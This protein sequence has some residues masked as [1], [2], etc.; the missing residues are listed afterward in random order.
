MI[1]G[2]IYPIGIQSF[3]ELRKMNCV[4]VD[5]TELIYRL[6]HTSKFV[7]LSRPRRFGK[8]LL[9]ST[10]RCYFE[11][12]KE[13]FTGLAMERL[14]T[15]WTQHPVLHFDLSN[16]RN[17]E[18]EDLERALSLKLDDY[19][20]I[21][22]RNEREVKL[23]ERL[24]GLIKRAYAKSGQKVVVLIDEYD[25]QILDVIHREKDVDAVRHI[26]RDFYSPLK[27]LDEYLRFV[28]FTGISM[29]S[30]LSIF[31]ELNNL[32]IISN[33]REY[34]SICGITEQ[35]LLDNFQEGIEKMAEEYECTKDEMVA[36]LKSSYDGYHFSKYSEGLYN[37]FSL[38]NA[39][40]RKELGSYW[41]A[42]GTP[43]ALIEMLKIYQ[44]QGK[45]TPEMLDSIQPVPVSKFQT[46]L[47]MQT[48]PMSLLYQSGYVT[49]TDYD[50]DDDL[51]YLGIPNSE[52]RVGLM[53]NLLPL[54][55]DVDSSDVEG[56]VAR[57]SA[58]LRKGNVDKAMKLLQS[59]L[60]SIPFMKGDKDILGDAEKT[61]A[62]YHRIF[63]FFFR[64]LH[65]EVTAEVRSAKG[66]TDVVV[67]TPKYIYVIEIKINATPEA[68]LQQIEEKGYATPYLTDGRELVK[69][70]VNF[71]TDTRTIDRWLTT[72]PN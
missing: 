40:S 63:F 65:N 36:K 62:Y 58:A 12:R 60:A 53:Q 32:N 16:P 8:S 13:L 51:Y 25:S 56:T 37:P 47:E 71:S 1:L 3:S 2:P 49:I 55:V 28:F 57:T 5:K 34:A 24:R 43:R 10:L 35:E 70:G 69:L 33:D 4:Y 42:S 30:Q 29:F 9:S 38:L 44:R 39:L 14:E 11:G 50:A 21:Y 41:F 48:G 26:M 52:V 15:D 22:G 31:S 68:A 6:T 17:V 64:M 59:L 54:Y 20:D 18:V 19:E 46:P 23:G 7:F 72:N 27:E 67:K 45:F 66:A 61:E